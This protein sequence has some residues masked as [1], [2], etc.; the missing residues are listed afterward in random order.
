LRLPF[1]DAVM[2]VVTCAFG[3]RNFQDVDAGLREIRRVLKAGGRLAILEFSTPANAVLRWLCQWY[4]R[5]ALPRLGRMIARDRSG[6]YDYLPRSIEQFDTPAQMLARLKSAGFV[7]AGAKL[8]N[9]GSV[10]VYS[11]IAAGPPA[12]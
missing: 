6:A 4:S 10:A 3:V 1:A 9:F 11:A 2:D 7:E 8:M 5:V 12:K